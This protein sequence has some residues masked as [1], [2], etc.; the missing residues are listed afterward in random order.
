M[1]FL[2]T[3]MALSLT[4]GLAGPLLAEG[5]DSEGGYNWFGDNDGESRGVYDQPGVESDDDGIGYD[6]GSDGYGLDYD[7]GYDDEYGYDYDAGDDNWHIND[8]ESGYDYE[9]D[10]GWFDD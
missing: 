10:D 9:T 6:Y 1:K 7:Y 8:E 3:L 4:L 2:A 5:Y